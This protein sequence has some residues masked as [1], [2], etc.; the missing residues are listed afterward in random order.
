MARKSKSEREA[1]ILAD[2]RAEFDAIQ[3]AC[4]DERRQCVED[5]RFYSIAGAQW[6]GPLGEQFENKPKL[7]NNKVHMGVMRIINEYRN[8]RITVDFVTKDGSQDDLADVCDGLYRADEQDSCAEEAYDNAFEEAAGGG[9]GAW[10]LRT[11]YEDEYDEDNEKQ[12]IRIEPIYDADT[13]VFFDLNAKRQDKSDAKSGY[14][15]YSMSRDAYKDKY[16]DDP[17]SWPK[18]V[19]TVN[20]DWNTPDVTYIAE[21]YRVEDVSEMV[22]TFVNPEGE[23]V[24]HTDDDLEDMGEK[25]IG[26]KKSD[27]S[28]IE[29]ALDDLAVKGVI[30]VKARK[31]K[32]RKVRKY[33]MSGARILEDC[34]YIAGKNIPI[35]PVYGKRWF[36]DNIERCMGAVRLAKDP[37][38]IYN[39]MVSKLAEIAALS[40]IR[41]PIFLSEQIAGLQDEWSKGNINDY[42]FYRINSIEAADGSTQ[43]AGPVGYL[44]PPDVPAALGALI[45]QTGQDMNE[46]LGMNQGAEQVVSNISGKAVEMIQSRLDM[47]SY[48]FMSNFAKA[49]RR[50][51]EIWLSMA[52]DTYVE[53]ERPMKSVGEQGDVSRVQLAKPVIGDNG[54]IVLRNDL[55]KADFDV[56]PDVGPSFTSRRDA[57]V[58]MLTGVGQMTDDPQDSKIITSLILMN[59]EGEGLSD[60]NRFYRK[61]LVQMGVIEPNEEELAA[62]AEAANQEQQPDPNAEYLQAAAGKEQALADK[63]V[64]DTEKSIAD[65]GKTRAETV[66]IMANMGRDMGMSEGA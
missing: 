32:R 64:A 8:N 20:F 61:Q 63:A 27:R 9:M 50:C 28:A 17:A 10:R 21:Y 31:V 11:C 1:Q 25:L 39:M 53:D 15:V 58:R 54:E 3:A 44:E 2:A 33:I 34:G 49:M 55:T 7:E 30:E 56:V 52:K 45:A 4:K 18:E 16:G 47:Q 60:V 66:E 14:V 65:A 19:N 36:V 40:P 43:T 59:A 24:K 35:V 41:K 13:S 37:Q 51:G 38:R 12:R 29:A 23:T 26:E 22:R 6:E 62:M 5:R 42:P 48:I 57:T 46:L